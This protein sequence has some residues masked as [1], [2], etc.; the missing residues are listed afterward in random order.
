MPSSHYILSHGI[1]KLEYFLAFLSCVPHVAVA[2]WVKAGDYYHCPIFSIQL[3]TRTTQDIWKPTRW[4]S[5]LLCL[6]K[7]LG[8]LIRWVRSCVVLLE[9]RLVDALDLKI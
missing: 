9:K 7:F 4:V 3:Y 5:A 6:V 2:T 8:E 1:Y